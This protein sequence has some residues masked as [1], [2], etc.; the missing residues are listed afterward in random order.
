MKI[1]DADKEKLTTVMFYLNGASAEFAEFRAHVGAILMGCEL[2]Y[3]RVGTYLHEWHV[4][5]ELAARALEECDEEFLSDYAPNLKTPEA[6]GF[7]IFFPPS[8]E[9]WRNAIRTLCKEASECQA[10]EHPDKKA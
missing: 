1:S 5:L 10:D 6:G 7:D 4:L 3:E 9:Y 8:T 2:H